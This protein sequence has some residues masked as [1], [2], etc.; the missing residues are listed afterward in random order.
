M[1]GN[2]VSSL[3]GSDPIDINKYLSIIN[4]MPAKHSRKIY[5]EKGY[6]HLYNRGVEKR[7]IFLDDQDYYIF[8][9]YLRYY[10]R[11]KEL[12][13]MEIKNDKTMNEMEKIKNLNFL[14]KL[15]NFHGLIKL[16]SFIL[17][18]NH[19]HLQ[20]QQMEKRAIEHFMRSLITKYVMYFNNKY[21][22]VGTLFQ[23]KYKGV[24]IASESQLLHLSRY[25]HLNIK[26]IVPTGPLEQ[27][28]YSSYS[29]Y[30]GQSSYDWLNTEIILRNFKDRKDQL[31]FDNYRSFVEGY[32][33][34]SDA[35]RTEYL[36]ILID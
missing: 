9:R 25:I 8:I 35:E 27:Y 17:M 30:I 5:I 21:H 16:M 6:Y 18:P 19:F 34:K 36:S 2:Q 22:R 1:I 28:E 26:E 11:P 31:G 32:R 20:L 4:Y 7:A 13:A 10:L 15:N 14:A 33:E 12:S 24:L 29:A 3:K 23:G